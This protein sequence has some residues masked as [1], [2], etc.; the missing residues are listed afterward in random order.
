MHNEVTPLKTSN[1]QIPPSPSEE[2]E[3]KGHLN[4][5][6]SWLNA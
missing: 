6:E 4:G 3:T 1:W 5:A 2:E